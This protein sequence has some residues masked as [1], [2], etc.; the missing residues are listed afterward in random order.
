MLTLVN[1]PEV[2]P[3]AVDGAVD[4][5]A[6]WAE[7]QRSI[8]EAMG[9][10]ALLAASYGCEGGRTDAP[11][12][13]HIA[14]LLAEP[15]S[16]TDAEVRFKVAMANLYLDHFTQVLDDATDAK[17]EHNAHQLHLSHHLLVKGMVLYQDLVGS[18]DFLARLDGYFHE[19]MTAER[20]LW[21]H[22]KQIVPYD[23]LEFT[24]IGERCSLMKAC[25]AAYAHIGGGVPLLEQVEH[26][27]MAVSTAV[28]LLDDLADW[29]QD[30]DA[31]IYTYPLTRVLQQLGLQSSREADPSKVGAMLLTHGA[32]DD[33]LTR[34]KQLL[35]DGRHAFTTIGA[36]GTVLLLDEL[37]T[38]RT[39]LAAQ[40][41]AGKRRVAAG[42]DAEEVFHTVRT[43]IDRRLF[44]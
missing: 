25:A 32:A 26:G 19:A 15:F 42:G 10:M 30:L 36:H 38:G 12:A 1:R 33:V 17:A 14:I 22:W 20:Y 8:R 39:S 13:A 21:R 37:E 27:L 3:V 9:D 35:C 16:V 23:E 40:L 6:V 29:R 31:E 44:H 7:Y 34:A 5:S 41:A 18:Q 24:R 4:A 11:L 43:R 2:L 28:Q